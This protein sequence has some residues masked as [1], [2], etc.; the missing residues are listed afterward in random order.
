ELVLDLDAAGD[1]HERAPDLAEELA[2][3]LELPPEEQA[4][5]RREEVRDRLGRGVRAVRRAEGVV[6]IQVTPLGEASR[7]LWVVL[8]LAG[9][10]AGVLEHGYP[11]VRKELAQPLPHGLP[12]VRWVVFFRAPEVGADADLPGFSLDQESKRGERGA[13]PRVVGDAPVL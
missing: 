5:V 11:L 6:H 3:L 4:G 9:I 8:R 1:E 2:Q 13:D 12:L 10:K 7:S